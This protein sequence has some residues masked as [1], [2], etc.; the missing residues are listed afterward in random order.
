[1]QRFKLIFLSPLFGNGLFATEP[2][3]QPPPAAT[4]V[5]FTHCH[6]TSRPSSLGGRS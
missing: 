1:M 4:D 2:K 6:D 3:V 5:W